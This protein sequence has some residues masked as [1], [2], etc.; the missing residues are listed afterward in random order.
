MSQHECVGE[1]PCNHDEPLRELVDLCERMSVHEVIE[2]ARELY[3]DVED[4][5]S[6]KTMSRK[7]LIRTM[8]YVSLF[9]AHPVKMAHSGSH[10]I[11]FLLCKSR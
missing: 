10:C 8:Q 9:M 1:A 6:S 3:P 11:F 4:F 2:R 7:S 5:V